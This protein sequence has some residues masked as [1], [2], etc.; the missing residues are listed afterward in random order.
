[1]YWIHVPTGIA[2]SCA[3]D[4]ETLLFIRTGGS[5]A[6]IFFLRALLPPLPLDARLRT[7]P[8][9]MVERFEAMLFSKTPLLL[10]FWSDV[11]PRGLKTSHFIS[12]TINKSR[13]IELIFVVVRYILPLIK[14]LRLRRPST[15]YSIVVLCFCT[16]WNSKLI[17][18]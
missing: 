9:E 2:A 12:G 18:L 13:E 6:A 15:L 5:G 4:T 8:D 10:R 3:E 7:E 11:E 1:M 17:L 16:P 14:S